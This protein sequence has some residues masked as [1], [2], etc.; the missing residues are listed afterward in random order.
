MDGFCSDAQSSPANGVHGVNTLYAGLVAHPKS[1]KWIFPSFVLSAAAVR[2][3]RSRF[4]QMAG[5]HRPDH[6]RRLRSVGNQ[7]GADVNPMYLTEFSGTP[8]CRCRRPT[9]G[10][11]TTRVASRDRPSRRNLR[12]GTAGDAR[13][14]GQAEANATAFTADGYFRTGDVG[15]FDERGFLKIVDRLKDM[16]LVSG[17]NVYPNE[18]ERS[19]PPVPACW[20]APASACRREDRRG[21]QAVRR[22]DA[23]AT[24]TARNWWRFAARK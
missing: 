9:S 15:V 18:I 17:F 24:L 3:H 7:P 22:Q 21:G 23:D 8:A 10:C 19:P 16:I 2:R 1:R 14:L 4:R 12:E 20:N 6:P 5:G 13:L 11:L